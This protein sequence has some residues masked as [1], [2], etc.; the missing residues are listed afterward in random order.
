MTL[1]LENTTRDEASLVQH[2]VKVFETTMRSD[3][4]SSENEYIQ[5]NGIICIGRIVE[6]NYLNHVLFSMTVSPKADTRKFNA[7]PPRSLALNI[8]SPGLLSTMQ[9]VTD[10]IHNRVLHPEE[11]EVEVKATGLNFHDIAVLLGQVSSDHIGMECA[12]VLTRVGK[13][14]ESDLEVGDRV[15]CVVAKLPDSLSF[16]TAAA[17]PIAYCTAYHS[18]YD[19]GRIQKDTLGQAAIQLAKRVTKISNMSSRSVATRKRGSSWIGMEFSKIT[20]SE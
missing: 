2:I 15:C 11:V 19:I 6:A 8:A 1:A 7:D 4:E 9:F 12:G 3:Q 18:L 10:D 17:I 13:S 5:R 14:I 16:A 20:Y